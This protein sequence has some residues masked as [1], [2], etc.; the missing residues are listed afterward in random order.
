MDQDANYAGYN[1]N[2]LG[3]TGSLEYVQTKLGRLERSRA[4]A[5]ESI[6]VRKASILKASEDTNAQ[7]DHLEVSQSR[8][9]FVGQ[10]VLISAAC[11]AVIEL[12][13]RG[14]VILQWLRSRRKRTPPKPHL[15]EE[16]IQQQDLSF[17]D[18]QP[19]TPQTNGR[20]SLSGRVHARDWQRTSYFGG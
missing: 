17:G 13:N 14:R 1:P 4:N 2:S 9:P 18:R 5:I 15:S 7:L 19:D 8:L 20:R 16:N 11:L 3:P 6:N 10:A 12:A